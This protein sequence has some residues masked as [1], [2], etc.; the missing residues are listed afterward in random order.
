MTAQDAA[1][2]ANIEPENLS[3]MIASICVQLL[4]P[5]IFP[6]FALMIPIFDTGRYVVLGAAV[7]P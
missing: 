5:R 3:R 4:L 2:T 6:G 1:M 7:T